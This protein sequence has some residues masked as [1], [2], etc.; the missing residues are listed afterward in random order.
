MLR[1]YVVLTARTRKEK[2]ETSSRSVVKC[3][4]E[5]RVSNYHAQ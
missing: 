4:L 3:L 2:S 5:E 1:Q